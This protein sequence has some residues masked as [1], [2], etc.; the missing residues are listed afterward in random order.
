MIAGALHL[1]QNQLAQCRD[2]LEHYESIEKL[3]YG[4]ASVKAVT[5]AMKDFVHAPHCLG[6]VSNALTES[7]TGRRVGYIVNMILNYTNVCVIRCSFCAFHVPPGDKRAYLITPEEAA[8]LVRLYY[9]RYR[10][11]QVLVQGGVNPNLRLDYYTRLFRAIREATG[12]RV[13]IHGLSPVEIEWIARL[14]GMKIRDVLLEL[15]EAGLSSI[16][17]GGAEI[18]AERPRKMLSP[19]KG[20]PESW[21][22]VMDEAMKLGIPVSAT[23][24]HSHVETLEERAEHLLRLLELQRRRGLILAFIPWNYEPGGAL[25]RELPY[26]AGGLEHLMMVSVSRLVFRHEIKYIQAG[27]LTAGKEL[28]QIALWYGA[29]DW[30]GTLYNEKVLPAAGVPLEV[31]VRSQVETLIRNAGKEPYERDNFYK[32]LPRSTS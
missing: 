24:M 21:I 8:R 31:L 16:P 27:W 5:D 14:E 11:R 20:G 28:A 26:A 9:D 10:I 3:L 23:M 30:G 1:V 15:K 18:L 19:A 2:V 32:Q 12:G 6:A 13:A 7:L 29:N 25:S 4:E 22:R 17:G